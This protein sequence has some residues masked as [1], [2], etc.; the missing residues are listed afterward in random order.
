M[1]FSTYDVERIKSMPEDE[2]T[3]YEKRIAAICRCML[4]KDEKPLPVV[5][6][7]LHQDSLPKSLRHIAF[8]LPEISYQ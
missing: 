1:A 7:R 4:L 8:Y 2:A 3:N 6:P 5:M